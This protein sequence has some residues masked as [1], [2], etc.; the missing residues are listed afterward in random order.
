MNTEAYTEGQTAYSEGRLSVDNPY[1]GVSYWQWDR[2]YWDAYD[3][4]AAE[5]ETTTYGMEYAY[6]DF[7]EVEQG[8][9]DDDPSPYDG[10]YSEM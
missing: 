4:H 1:S 10:T 2:G 9:W 5:A 6:G 3:E 7:S 8:R